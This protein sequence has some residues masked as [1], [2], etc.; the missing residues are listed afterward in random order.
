MTNITE[1]NIFPV[2]VN[3][4]DTDDPVLG[5]LTGE[6]NDPIIALTH[7]SRYLYNYQSSFTGIEPITTTATI[8]NTYLRKLIYINATA[9]LSLNLSAV[10]TFLPG[11]CL[12]F[13]CKNATGKNAAI[14]PQAGEDIM[15]GTLVK[16]VWLYDT[17]EI[18]LVAVDRTGGGPAT[19]WE[20]L[21]AKGNFDLVGNDGMVRSQ[22]RNSII[23]NG[24]TGFL[25]ADYARLW[26]IVSATA[27]D[28]S[29]WLSDA[30]NYK[31]FFSAGN[32]TT[33]FRVPDMRSMF[34]RGLDLGRG[35]SY[36]RFGS[37]AGAY[38]PDEVGPHTH[39]GVPNKVNDT[40]RGEGRSS[41]FSVDNLGN[42]LPNTG[43]T[44][45]S[46]KNAGLIPI[47]YF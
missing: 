30:L 9:N 23:A 1:E 14:V 47:I 10:N 42:T 33:T 45:T 12:H 22:P 25:R 4:Y 41:L 28:D 19:G 35:V 18:V 38:A 43:T 39:P 31:C 24:T 11:Q 37:T 2:N 6:S 34:W 36:F 3:R 7:R 8:N 20:I 16:N 26:D 27:I 13:K 40:D 15:E 29:V 44:E 46:V 32:G 21:N 17:E 5:G